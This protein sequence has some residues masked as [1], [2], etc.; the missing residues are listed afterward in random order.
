M[1]RMT[2]EIISIEK[3][4]IFPRSVYIIDILSGGRKKTGSRRNRFPIAI[5]T[6]YI[7]VDV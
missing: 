7:D 2:K 4:T 5:N 1:R 3:K 6:V